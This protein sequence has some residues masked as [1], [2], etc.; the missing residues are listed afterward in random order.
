MKTEILYGINP[1]FEALKAGKR[2]IHQIYIAAHK[3]SGRISKIVKFAESKKI[4]VKKVKA[5]QLK[6]IAGTGQHQGVS[7]RVNPYPM[8]DL[9]DITDSEP[10][11]GNHLFLLLLDN[12]LDPQNLGAIIR[13]ALG[14][15]ISGI[16]LPKDRS[17]MP[18][19]AVSKSSA[20]AIE[21]VRLIRVTNMV[22]T[23]RILKKQ[24]AWIVGLDQEAEKTVYS[25]DLTG[26][27]A[28]VIGG[29]A[30]GI[31]PL[32]K[33]NC[34][35]IASIPQT[36]QLNSLNASVA[37]AIAMYEAFRQRRIAGNQE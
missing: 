7:A 24:G 17:A 6:S 22:D 31:R 8:A 5:T 19:P 3:T 23:I 9:S 30:K 26:S 18:T 10:G 36:G 1:V 11:K 32:V 13:T 25:S 29:E 34:D 35:F 14:V 12:V 27:L 33:K 2:K 15:G 4:P 16:I 20:G 28:I 21:H 37:A